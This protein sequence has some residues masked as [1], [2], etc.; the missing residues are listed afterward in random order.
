MLETNNKDSLYLTIKKY[1]NR[2]GVS[3]F[4]FHSIE[5]VKEFGIRQ[6]IEVKGPMGTGL[7]V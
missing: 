1:N 6:K 4:V 2:Y 5:C 3:M 7:D